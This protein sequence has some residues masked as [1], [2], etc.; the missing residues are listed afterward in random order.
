MKKETTSRKRTK[1]NL[2]QETV[3][4]LTCD[5]LKLV[6]GGAVNPTRTGTDLVCC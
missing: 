3:A 4:T 5:M 1:L 6:A 2:H